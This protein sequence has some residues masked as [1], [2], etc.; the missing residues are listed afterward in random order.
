M[1]Q[2]SVSLSESQ[3][4][5]SSMELM[6]TTLCWY[7]QLLMRHDM[8]LNQH[9]IHLKTAVDLK[10]LKHVVTV[11]ATVDNVGI[12]SRLQKIFL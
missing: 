3:N 6:C 4:Y 12:W 2:Y 1:D 11:S 10:N 9:I 8:H 7:Y 5:Q